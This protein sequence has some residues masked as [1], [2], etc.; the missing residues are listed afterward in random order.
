MKKFVFPLQCLMTKPIGFLRVPTLKL[1]DQIVWFFSFLISLLFG[2][3]FL[4]YI[5]VWF[6][7]LQSNCNNGNFSRTSFVNFLKVNILFL[8]L[9]LVS[10]KV[11]FLANIRCC[12]SL[13]DWPLHMFVFY[14]FNVSHPWACL[15][16]LL[17]S[18]KFFFSPLEDL[19]IS[20]CCCSCCLWCFS[21]IG[22]GCAFCSWC[23]DSFAFV[24]LEVAL[25]LFSCN[26]TADV[27]PVVSSSCGSASFRLFGHNPLI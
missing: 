13:L 6:H 15:I 14:F 2:L 4:V 24:D 8:F 18:I 10:R 23:A 9:F 12:L 5:C 25:F 3:F 16:I 26:L 19:L 21:G 27:T 7:L 17:I 22:D 1:V 20:W 11:P